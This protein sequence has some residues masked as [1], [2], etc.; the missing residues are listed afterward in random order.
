VRENAADTEATWRQLREFCNDLALLRRGDQN[1]ARLDIERQRVEIERRRAAIEEVFEKDK[2]KNRLE[3]A[4]RTL[5]NASSSAPK[6]IPGP[7]QP[8]APSFTSG[9][10]SQPPTGTRP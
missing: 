10:G 1:A 7:A 3:I 2:F 5:M 6:K 4:K 9:G 8:G